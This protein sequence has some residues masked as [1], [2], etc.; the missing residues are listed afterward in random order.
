MSFIFI[1][2]TL[3]HITS[4]QTLTP[5]TPT[6]SPLTPSPTRFIISPTLT[7]SSGQ[8]W[9]AT[10]NYQF[11]NAYIYCESTSTCHIHC[12]APYSC[13]Y[14]TII[15]ESKS[16]NC[17]IQCNENESCHY[18]NIT[19]SSSLKT[20]LLCSTN[21]SCLSSTVTI[22]SSIITV[23][24]MHQQSC[25]SSYFQLISNN[26]YIENITIQC[27]NNAISTS[28]Y[29]SACSNAT[30]NIH[31]VNS[32]NIKCSYYDC[33]ATTFNAS[34]VLYDMNIECF[35][36]SACN[37]AIIDAK[38]TNKLSL[39][40]DTESSCKSAMIYC[41][42]KINSCNIHCKN[43]YNSTCEL[44]D[45]YAV[46]NDS[47]DLICD[48][49]NNG[50]NTCYQLEIFC[51]IRNQLSSYMVLNDD[52]GNYQCSE[53]NCCPLVTQQLKSITCAK[54]YDCNINCDNNPTSCSNKIING[55]IAESLHI[56]CVSC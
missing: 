5:T 13:L 46:N 6:Q 21:N 29:Y 30:F 20:N 51:G 28:S 8:Y 7:N 9:I 55:T 3:S 47:L 31:S 32:I 48:T 34:N 27:S 14:S 44:L 25:S 1:Y 15:C 11:E 36:N 24:C 2:L 23:K 45:I 18:A 35:S 40:C 43:N 4:S 56:L 26:N 39:K 53:V 37:K 12:N 16:S 17:I 52:T 41:P 49:N 54:G 50:I 38:F 42:Y 19:S 33:Y 10:N 22:S